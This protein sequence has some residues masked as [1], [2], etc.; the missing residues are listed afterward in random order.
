MP[1][2]S[3][4]SDDALDNVV[5]SITHDF[6]NCGIR[7]MKGFLL[8]QGI[9]VP[10][11]R[12]RSSLRRTDPAGIL[13]RTAL[14]N[15]V[16]RREYSVPGPLSF[17]HLDGIHKLIRWG[18]VIHGCVDGYSRRLMFFKCSTNNKAE[19]VLQLFVKAVQDF[20]LPSRVRGDQGAENVEVAKY[21]FSHKA[22]GPE[23]G[24]FHC[25]KELPQPKN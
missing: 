1:K 10:W 22:R 25:W 14:L 7:R 21:M 17:W 3:A 19:T 23:R 4:L 24:S 5:A 2:Y 15:I 9:R 16:I 18:F 11:M 6:P 12:V 20:G 13:L 8:A